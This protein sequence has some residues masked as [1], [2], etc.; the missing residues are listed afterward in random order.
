MNSAH[1]KQQYIAFPIFQTV[2]IVRIALRTWGFGMR[3]VHL[4]DL[5]PFKC[6]KFRTNSNTGWHEVLIIVWTCT[7]SMQ[8]S[9]QWVGDAALSPLRIGLASLLPIPLDV[10]ACPS[11]EGASRRNSTRKRVK[12]HVAALP[13]LLSY[14]TAF[15]GGRN[16]LPPCSFLVPALSGMTVTVFDEH[17]RDAANDNC[18]LARRRRYHDASW[19]Q[20]KHI[21]QGGTLR[22]PSD[23]HQH[24]VAAT[25]TE[26]GCRREDSMW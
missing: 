24:D 25:L 13:D 14:V 9:C 15:C 22:F 4:K 20:S 26:S 23:R 11:G 5:F 8:P 19:P 7:S 21:S 1:E 12:L 3:R 2:N 17:N 16:T 6:E 18:A 10:T